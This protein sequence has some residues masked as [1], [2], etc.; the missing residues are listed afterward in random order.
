MIFSDKT[1][2]KIMMKKWRHM[3]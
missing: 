1:S 2:Y 3:M